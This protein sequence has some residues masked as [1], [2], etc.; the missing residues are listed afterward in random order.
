MGDNF[1]IISYDKYVQ[2]I[3]TIFILI[4][5]KTCQETPIKVKK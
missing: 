5:N 4:I 1:L 2:N 3:Q